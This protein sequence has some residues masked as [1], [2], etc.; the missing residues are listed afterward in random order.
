MRNLFEELFGETEQQT[1][2]CNQCLKILPIGLFSFNSGA[3]HRRAKCKNCDSV[4]RQQRHKFR[5]LTPPKGH[6]C[7][8]CNRSEAKVEGKG[9]SKSGAWCL[10]HNHVT[11]EYRG[12]LC[13]ECNRAL[14]NFK[15]S[16]PLLESAI[17]Y[18]TGTKSQ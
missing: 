17:K 2:T 18:L 9:G 15:D 5:S 10:D 7:P 6:V 4:Q 1:K 14:G 8:I 16:I 3:K 11:G 13:H 12:F